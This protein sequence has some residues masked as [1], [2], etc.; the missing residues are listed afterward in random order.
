MSQQRVSV[1][2]HTPETGVRSV[3]MKGRV[4]ECG[5]MTLRAAIDRVTHD[6]RIFA[7]RGFDVNLHPM[8][9]LHFV[10]PPLVA[11]EICTVRNDILK[12]VLEEDE[13]RPLCHACGCKSKD[14]ISLSPCGHV[15][16]MN[17]CLGSFDIPLVKTE[18]DGIHFITIDQ[19]HWE[20]AS[21]IPCPLCK[22]ACASA[23]RL[24]ETIVFR[25]KRPTL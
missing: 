5:I 8:T 9:D 24:C 21:C 7:M 10:E 18:K 22:I 4:Y 14:P 16:C 25:R 1:I 17:P 12:A 23:V 2:W 19:H 3:I 6:V 11:A 20:K 13:H 15:F